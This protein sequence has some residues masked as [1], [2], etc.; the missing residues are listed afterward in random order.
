MNK[1][2]IITGLI[3]FALA[4]LSPFW[5]NIVTTTQ[6]APEPE[7]V[8]KAKT[9]KKCVLDKYEMRANHMS[10][11][12]DWRDSVVR[13]ADRMYTAENGHSFNM[14]LSTGENSC[15]GCHEDKAKF[16]DSCHTYASVTPYCWECHTNPKEI[17]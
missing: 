10:L 3:I 7:L 6:A 17:Q 8:G 4:V 2:T 15:L 13:D 16:C 14:S 12:D 9:E 5:F 1:N 11:L